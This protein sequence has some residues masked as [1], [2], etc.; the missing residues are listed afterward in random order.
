PAGT[1]V[2]KHCEEQNGSSTC[3]P[4]RGDEYVEYPNDFHKCLGCQVCREDQVELRRCQADRNTQCVCRNGTFC[5]PDHPCEMCQKCRSRCPEDQVEQAPCTPHSDRQCGPPTGT[6]SG[7]SN[8]WVVSIVV[9]AAVVVLVPLAVWKCRRRRSQAQLVCAFSL[10][11]DYLVRQLTRCQRGDMGTQDN[12]HNEQLSRDKLLPRASDPMTPS[13]PGPE[14]MVPRT[15][16]PVVKPRRNLVPVPERDPS[17]LLRQSFY[18]FAQDV[19]CKDW[20]RYGRALDL[21]ENDI[22][23][24]EMND[25]YTLEPFF[26]MLNTWHSRQ[27]LNASVNTLLDTLHQINLG[28][29][30]ENISSKLVQQGYFQYE[31]S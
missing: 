15:S 31:V 8:T 29:I 28:G 27:G 10:L 21:L 14:V 30:A 9:V 4:C 25:K 24:A 26:Q 16:H 6:F 12:R 11:Q 5:S 19:P 13:A 2:E 18:I 22:A 1:Y 20:K 17:A 7:S 23:L 3:S